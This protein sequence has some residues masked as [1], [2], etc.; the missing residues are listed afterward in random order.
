[1]KGVQYRMKNRPG[2]LPGCLD[3][4]P[5]APAGR[6]VGGEGESTARPVLG[7]PKTDKDTAP[8]ELIQRAKRPLT[9]NPSPALGR[10]EPRAR[11]LLESLVVLL[12]PFLSIFL[13]S[14]RSINAA[15]ADWEA[16]ARVALSRGDL[17]DARRTAESALQDGSSAAAAHELLGYINYR[18]KRNEE[19]ISHFQAAS[20]Q[21]RS[22]LELTKDWSAAL[23]ALGRHS[24][25]RELLEKALAQDPSQMD[26]RYRLAGSYSTQGKWKEAWPHWETAYRQGLRHSGV[27]LQLARARFA[28][29]Q[30]VEAVELLTGFAAATTAIDPLLEAGKLLF[31]KA[32]YRQALAPLQKVW[33]QKPG[34][35]DAGMYLALSHYLIE[36][37]AESE[38]ALKEIQ[39]IPEASSEYLLLSGSVGA[40]LGKWN[41]A[42]IALEDA[43]KRFPQRADG[44]LNLGLFCLERGDRKRAMDLFDKASRLETRGNKVI[45]TIRS[46]RNCE[47]LRPPEGLSQSDSTRKEPYSQLAEQLYARQQSG[48]ALEVFLLA[49]ESDPRSEKAYAGI[50]RICSETDSVPQARA[51]LEKGLELHPQSAAM[52]FNLGLAFQALGQPNEAVRQFQQAMELRRPR[53]SPLDWIQLGTAQQA[54]GDSK[55]AEN[56]FLKG[57]S[58]DPTLAQGHFELGKLYFQQAAYDRAE[59]SLEKAIQLDPRLLGAYYQYGLVC[60]RNGKPE[61]GKTFLNTFHQKKELYAPEASATEPPASP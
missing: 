6:G 2:T 56:S 9:P 34:A 26:L 46:R 27:V 61:R 14:P 57:L 52:H 60:M 20:S 44:H 35:Y 22:G 3:S 15:P 13:A 50:G 59:K 39:A 17:D 49:L 16:R 8:W 5:L 19:A 11:C 38:K 29:G 24:E 55:E 42:R 54:G 33:Q 1:M 32:L 28:V 18:Q 30:D 43:T 4:A 25:A 53:T 23:L 21:G 51:F 41:E 58:L 36:H 47:G 10:R 45:Y 7:S 37:Y 40:R 31:E 48:S 12:V